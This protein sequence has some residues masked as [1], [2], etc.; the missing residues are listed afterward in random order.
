MTKHKLN[1]NVLSTLHMPIVLI[2]TIGGA[3][4]EDKDLDINLLFKKKEAVTFGRYMGIA[5]VVGSVVFLFL[6]S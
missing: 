3:A 6:E 4:V 2:S 5:P 1:C